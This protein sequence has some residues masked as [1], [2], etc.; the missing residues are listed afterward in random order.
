[1]IRTTGV[2]YPY[3]S[4]DGIPQSSAAEFVERIT[5]AKDGSRLDYGIT[6]T[7]PGTFLEPVVM[8]KSWVW[9]SDVAVEPYDCEMSK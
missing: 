4:R 7:D 6:I 1:M 2:S 3:F 9:L 8:E 5:A